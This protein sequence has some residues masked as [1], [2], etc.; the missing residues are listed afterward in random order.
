LIATD[1][2]A[3]MIGALTGGP[4]GAAMATLGTVAVGTGAAG[5]T[6]KLVQKIANSRTASD[7]SD[8]PESPRGPTPEFDPF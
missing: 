1:A 3:G 2:A 8:P 4:V 5:L 7:Q 6:G